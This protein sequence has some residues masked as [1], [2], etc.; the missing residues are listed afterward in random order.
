MI[1]I[2]NIASYIPENF[3]SNFD[4]MDKFKI[5]EHFIKNKIGVLQVAQKNIEEETSDMCV[6]A[7]NN[8]KVDDNNL[9][10][11]IDCIVVCTQNPDSH[12]I[13]HTSAIVHNKLNLSENC[14]SFDISLGCSG[15][16]YSLSIIKSFM[17]SNGLK[18]GLLFTAD[19]YSKIVNR[20]DKDTVLLF[21]DAATVTLLSEYNNNEEYWYPEKFFFNTSNKDG[22]ALQ[23]NDGILKMNGRIVFNFCATKVP[24]Q[25]KDLLN[26]NK[27]EVKDIDLF[28]FHQGSKYII[29]TL[30]RK[31]DL[32]IE[33]VPIKLLLYG[34]TVSS[35]IPLVLEE[36]LEEK[37]LNRIILSGF[38][39]GLSW[40]SCLI[41][42]N[43]R[44]KHVN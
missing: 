40:A 6:K 35:S 37:N 30:I 10:D 33:K 3:E 23:N 43:E 7:F 31:M 27:L 14:A 21:G 41:T 1:G 12:G 8:F 36:Y 29:E 24:I 20:D 4:K 9:S 28:V 18:N 2:R 42:R 26:Y 34:N 44:R 11:K 13:P 25:I 39:V 19:P 32:P 16:V 22:D 5:D 17:E 15:Y 38:G